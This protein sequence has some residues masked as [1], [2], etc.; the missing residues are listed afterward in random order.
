MHENYHVW[1]CFQLSI[2]SGLRLDLDLS[3]KNLSKREIKNKESVTDSKFMLLC[4]VYIHANIWGF[5]IIKKRKFF[6]H[7]NPVVL[8]LL[9][10]TLVVVCCSSQMVLFKL[11]FMRL[12]MRTQYARYNSS[13]RWIVNIWVI[14]RPAGTTKRFGMPVCGRDILQ[15]V[16]LCHKEAVR[17]P[18]K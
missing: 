16:M 9:W 4:Y 17:T 10:C 3:K 12:C 14:F 1:N 6:L 5:A 18:A 15:A 8:F 13:G 7:F 2:G 11:F